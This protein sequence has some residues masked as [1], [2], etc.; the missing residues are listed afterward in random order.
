MY[1]KIFSASL[2]GL[3]AY[4]IEIEV[5]FERALPYFGIVGLPDA[6]VKESRERV[7]AALGNSGVTF[8]VK[9][10]TV[11]LAPADLKK[12]GASF[13]LPIAVG[14]MAA[15]G[16]INHHELDN[17]LFIGELSFEGKLRS[18]KGI[19][20]I[21]MAAKEKG[22]KRMI[23][24]QSNASEATIINGIEIYAFKNLEMVLDFLLGKIQIIPVKKEVPNFHYISSGCDFS[25][26]RGQPYVKRGIMVSA[27]G[28]HNVLMIGPPGSGKTMI[29][30]RIPTVLPPLSLEEAIELTRIYSVSGMLK[31]N[32][33]IKQRPFRNPHHTASDAAIIGGG[34]IP[35]PGEVSLAH[36]GVLFLDEFPEFKK[37]VLNT[38]RQPLEDNTVTISRAERAVTYPANFM[39]VA[40]MN[41]CPCGYYGHPEIVC[42]CSE[43][44][45]RNYVSRI[46][47]PILDRIDI[48]LEVPKVTYGDMAESK[49]TADSHEMMKRVVAAREIQ[50]ARF[51]GTSILSNSEM[52]RRMIEDYCQTGESGKKLL[53]MAMDRLGLSARAYDK[54]L[55]VARTIADLNGAEKIQEEDIMEAIQY[56]SVDRI[57]K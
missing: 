20:S 56:R 51:K 50:L 47:G 46:S 4:I 5:Q 39:F 21:I 33:L 54:I 1:S 2:Y 32:T 57:L 28:N 37:N 42:R 53:K 48:Q 25:E 3:D 9:K 49:K 10:I 24:P 55:R 8:P 52:P 27:A 23:I 15:A 34:V 38:L 29:A 13:D 6:T 16:I 41:P 36:R 40:S 31:K 14:I 35:K 45:I 26:V 22:F 43:E 17:T 30:R 12:E 18:V 7:K 19:L 44:K 11:N